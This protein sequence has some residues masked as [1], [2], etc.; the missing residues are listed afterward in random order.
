MVYD[1][2]IVDG[3]KI[4][5]ALPAA[6]DAMFALGD[7]LALELLSD[8]LDRYNYSGNLASMRKIIETHDEAFWAGSVYHSAL[9]NLDNTRTISESAPAVF[10][11]K[12]WAMK[13]LSTRL[14]FWSQLRHDN[15]LYIKQS[16][17]GGYV[18]E[19][20]DGY[21]EPYPDFYRGLAEMSQKLKTVL[22]GYLA[23]VDLSH[24]A[25]SYDSPERVKT[26][27][28]QYL[29][30]VSSACN[31]LESISQ[32][33]LKGETL[34][35]DETAFIKNWYREESFNNCVPSTSYS[36]EYFKMYYSTYTGEVWMN[37]NQDP[38]FFNFEPEIADVHTCPESPS[39][40]FKV[41]SVA[42]GGALPIFAA[43]ENPLGDVVL[44]TGAVYDY[45]EF[46]DGKRYSDEEWESLFESGT[47]PDKPSWMNDS[48]GGYITY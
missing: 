27:L 45:Y 44:Y 24:S 19:Y 11:Q 8:E 15:M 20:P 2:I 41:L 16:F 6:F 31:T 13:M 23:A 25:S 5:R 7:N 37:S 21:V 34:D 48:E 46:S 43:V 10:Q 14:G 18:C 39:F 36:G 32:K 3:E 4:K 17:S 47:V 33:E 12:P 22:E 29:S 1:R 40:P 35:S 38:F 30:N 26:R 28:L 9:K 42:T